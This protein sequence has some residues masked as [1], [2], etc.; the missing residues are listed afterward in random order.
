MKKLIIPLCLV[1]TACT[2]VPKEPVIVQIPVAVSCV[3]ESPIRPTLEPLPEKATD[4]DKVRVLS[5]RYLQ[6]TQY[7]NVLEAI[8]KG[9]EI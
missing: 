4:F 6:Q 8:V 7:I 3:K 5:I 1:S 9:C 2:T